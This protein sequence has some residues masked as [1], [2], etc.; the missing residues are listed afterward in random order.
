[1]S[2]VGHHQLVGTSSDE[3]EETSPSPRPQPTWMD[4]ESFRC[5]TCQRML[6]KI[7]KDA[8]KPGKALEVKCYGCKE[9]NYLMATS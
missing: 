3:I 4:L 7:S 6:L 2:T 5:R 9:K 8:L 1:M